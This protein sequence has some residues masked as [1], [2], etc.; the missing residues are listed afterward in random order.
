MTL[1]EL[2]SIMQPSVGQYTQ[3]VM[4]VIY[5]NVDNLLEGKKE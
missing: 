1:Y 5:D 3:F 2:I 4:L